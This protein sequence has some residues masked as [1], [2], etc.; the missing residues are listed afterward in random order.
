[1]ID[2]SQ[3]AFGTALLDYLDGKD[4]A[5]LALQVQGG[6]TGPTMNPEWFSAASSGGTAWI[7]KSWCRWNTVLSWTLG[8]ARAGRLCICGSEGCQLPLSMPRRVQLRYAGA[9][10]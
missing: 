4:V 2:P 3:D 5:P 7:R 9:G 10:A 8:R 6:K 1:M